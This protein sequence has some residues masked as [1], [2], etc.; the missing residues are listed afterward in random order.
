MIPNK[1][2]KK[3]D[4]TKLTPWTKNMFYVSV[5]VHSTLMSEN[6]PTN[7]QNTW[8]INTSVMNGR[9]MVSISSIDTNVNLYS[10]IKY[11]SVTMYLRG[12]LYDLIHK[13]NYYSNLKKHNKQ[14]HKKAP[15]KSFYL[16]GYTTGFDSRNQ[17]SEPPC[18][19]Q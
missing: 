6:K 4:T 8:L 14:Y 7:K 17:N 2:L 10:I 13:L 9:F 3:I 12:N 18:T 5:Y 16:S 15:F 11:C 19:S 1:R